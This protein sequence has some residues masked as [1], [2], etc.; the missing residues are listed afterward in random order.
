MAWNDEMIADLKQMWEDGLTTGEIGKRIGVSKNSIVGKVHRLGLSGRPS[1]IKKKIP[2]EAIITETLI[3]SDV[4]EEAIK[5]PK[6]E[7]ITP[8]EELAPKVAPKKAVVKKSS[9]TSK[10]KSSDTII[11]HQEIFKETK[12]P[13]NGKFTVADLDNH[14]CRWPIGDPKD[15][16]FHF[17]GKETR[18][19]NT[20]CDEHSAIAFVRQSKK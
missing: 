4:K 19:G 20:Y 15:D 16:D 14:T 17:C 10:T 6:I 8:K 11:S 5:A 1:P 3:S 2:V 7:V 12:K 9:T 18:F 13:A